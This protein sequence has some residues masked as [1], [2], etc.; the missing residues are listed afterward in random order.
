MT[1]EK[2]AFLKNF[3]EIEKPKNGKDMMPFLTKYMQDAKAKGIT[4]SKEEILE[5]Y[6]NSMDSLSEIEKEKV[7]RILSLFHIT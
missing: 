2:E 3:C 1:P 7:H 4:F 5:L 6:N